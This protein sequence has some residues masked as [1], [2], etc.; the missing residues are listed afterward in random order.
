M[1]LNIGLFLSLDS[2]ASGG[3]WRA[4]SQDTNFEQVSPN[5]D[6]LERRDIL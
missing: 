3:D 5:W 2:D 1:H 4:V 6:V